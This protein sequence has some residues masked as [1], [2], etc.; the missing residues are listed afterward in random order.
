MVDKEQPID[1]KNRPNGKTW[2]MTKT[3]KNVDLYPDES[4][5]EDLSKR[6]NNIEDK[7]NKLLNIVTDKNNE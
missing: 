4:T 5:N 7:L 1:S 6:V 3:Q 2:D